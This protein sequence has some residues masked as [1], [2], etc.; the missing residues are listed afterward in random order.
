MFLS[1]FAKLPCIIW[2]M[3]AIFWCSCSP[4]CNY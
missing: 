3:H 1:V 4:N 2:D